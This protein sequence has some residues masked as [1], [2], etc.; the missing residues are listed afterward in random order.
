MENANYRVQK[1]GKEFPLFILWDYPIHASYKPLY[2]SVHTLH[3]LVYC[4]IE[5]L[6]FIHCNWLKICLAAFTV[7]YHQA[8]HSSRCDVFFKKN[9]LCHIRQKNVGVFVAYV[10]GNLISFFQMESWGV[11]DN[12]HRRTRKY[13]YRPWDF[14]P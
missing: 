11:S 9:W 13:L 14:F 5:T 4:A 7:C 12:H 3:K 1:D 8:R 10:F 2:V 6:A